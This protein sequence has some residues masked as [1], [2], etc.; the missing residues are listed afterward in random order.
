MGLFSRGRASGGP[1]EWFYCLV[2]KK[3]EE[4]PECPARDRL[5]PYSTPAEAQHATEISEQRNQEWEN[6]PRWH[7]EPDEGPRGP[8]P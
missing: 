4:G 8:R 5:G 6:D 1:G 3:V 7:D 2:H